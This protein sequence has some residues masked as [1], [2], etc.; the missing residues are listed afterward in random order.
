MAADSLEN[1]PQRRE[2]A[3][4]LASD[5]ETETAPIPED[6]NQFEQLAARLRGLGPADLR[7]K[8]VTAGLMDRP[9]SLEGENYRCLECMYYL[10]NR[11]WCDL[12][13]M[14]LPVEPDWWCRLWRI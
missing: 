7:E 8:A 10:K 13:D 2:L 12:P 1:D 4:L 9:F 11:R 3:E 6:Q 14:N 5:L